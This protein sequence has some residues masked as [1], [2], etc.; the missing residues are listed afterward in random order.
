MAV[1]TRD[2]PPTSKPTTEKARTPAL[3]LALPLQE[4]EPP[5][6][7]SESIVCLYGRKGIGK[8]SLASQFTDSLT[9][10]FERGRRNLPILMVPKKDEGQ[11]TWETTLGYVELALAS[12][13]IQTIVFDTVDR[14][15]ERCMEYVCGKLGVKHP[16]DMNDYGK[17]WNVVKTEFAALLGV[18]QD[19]GK[20]VVLISHEK[21]KPLAKKSKGLKREDSDS[22]FQYERM[23]PTCSNQAFETIQEICDFVLYY[24]YTDEYRTITVRSP[25][26]LAWTSCGVGDTFLNPDGS[27][28]NTFKVGSSPKEAYQ[29]LLDAYANK[30]QDI[31]FKPAKK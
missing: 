28:I 29:S 30:A 27:T 11:L 20:G 19:S 7:L 1:V 3:S 13:D 9:F 10:M 31:D 21:A 8:T 15:Y 17:T 22:I 26:D 4:N 23:E 18:I 25:N 2:K 14:A 24:S 16:N 12:D 5:T 6:E